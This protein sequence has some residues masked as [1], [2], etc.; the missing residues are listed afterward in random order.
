MKVPEGLPRFVSVGE[1]G[2]FISARGRDR[3]LPRRGSSRRWRS[4]SAP[5]SASRATRT[6]RSRTR[7]TTCSRRSS[8]S[9]GAD[10]S[11][12]S[13]GSRSPI[14]ISPRLLERLQS[15]L[16]V[17]A[18]QVYLRGPARPRRAD[19]ARGA[20]SPRAQGRSLARRDECRA[21]RGRLDRDRLREIAAGDILVHHPYESFATSFGRF[22]AARRRTPT[23]SGS[24]RRSTARATTR[25]S[26]PL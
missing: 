8:S 21:S 22:L 13:S 12:R 4:S 26:C 2:L 1:R 3:A 15:G 24:R 23:S 7:P 16:R 11:A 10:A 17:D 18:D 14:A 19:A 25:R 5:S 20:R 9:C 6:T